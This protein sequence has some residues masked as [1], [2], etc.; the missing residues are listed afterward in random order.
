M[1]EITQVKAR[2]T[3]QT[4]LLH[5]VN[6]CRMSSPGAMLEMNSCTLSMANVKAAPTGAPPAV[7]CIRD[8]DHCLV[9][10]TVPSRST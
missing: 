3:R 4:G 1:L 10:C 5:T 8:T 2:P 7:L 6:L 9:Y